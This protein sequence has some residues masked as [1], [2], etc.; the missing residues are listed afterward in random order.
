MSGY[1]C[2][3]YK[4]KTLTNGQH[5]LVTGVL[6]EVRVFQAIAANRARHIVVERAVQT[7]RAEGLPENASVTSATDTVGP[8]LSCI[9][10]P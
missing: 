2:N 3:I 6:L 10:E 8:L 1:S 9:M 4:F 5:K 7:S